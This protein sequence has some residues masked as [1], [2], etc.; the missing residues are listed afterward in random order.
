MSDRLTIC[1]C[2][3]RGLISPER[4]AE[5]AEEEMSSPNWLLILFSWM[6]Q[7]RL[8]LKGKLSVRR[9]LRFLLLHFWLH[10]PVDPR[11]K[12]GFCV[13]RTTRGS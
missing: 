11:H 7:H 12:P 10:L 6:K 5:L 8:F 1:A 13:F 3:W 9:G 2:R 4:V